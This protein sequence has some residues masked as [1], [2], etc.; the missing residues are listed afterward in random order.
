L[1]AAG[2]GK[3]APLMRAL[4]VNMDFPQKFK[5]DLESERG[6]VLEPDDVWLTYAVCGVEHRSCGWKGWILES[7]KKQGIELSAQTDQKCPNCKMTMFRTNASIR[8]L[9]ALDQSVPLVDGVDYESEPIEY[10]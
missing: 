3:A 5:K 6:D 8:Y 1:H 4:S 9:P 2:R 10:E 7:A